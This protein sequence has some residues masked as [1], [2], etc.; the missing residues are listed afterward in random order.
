VGR[1]DRSTPRGFRGAL[2]TL[3]DV[4][5]RV[6]RSASVAKRPNGTENEVAKL[7]PAA[8]K[9]QGA[10]DSAHGWFLMAF[11]GA[12]FPGRTSSELTAA[13]EEKLYPLCAPASKAEA[14]KNAV[15]ACTALDEV[16][17]DTCDAFLTC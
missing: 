8:V 11:A 6:Q 10:V 14:K 13:R 7:L 16:L 12:R 15:L 2:S 1:Q 17:E 9:M 4:L 5:A 3:L